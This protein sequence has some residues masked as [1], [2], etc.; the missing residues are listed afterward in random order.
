MT[1]E[2]GSNRAD[3]FMLAESRTDSSNP[4]P[5]L[6]AIFN[7]LTEWETL[8]QQLERDRAQSAEDNIGGPSL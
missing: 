4:Q 1:S 5:D 3:P 6:E 2:W 8:L 7:T